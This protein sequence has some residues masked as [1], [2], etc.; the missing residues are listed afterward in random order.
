MSE[1]ELMSSRSRL[2]QKVLRGQ[3]SG[4]KTLYRNWIS[5][6]QSTIRQIQSEDQYIKFS[7]LRRLAAESLLLFH[8][9]IGT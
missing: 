8:S 6:I 7:P 1:V 3:S 4:S 5:L 9:G 2:D